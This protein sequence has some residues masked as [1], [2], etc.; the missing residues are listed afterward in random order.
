MKNLLTP[1]IEKRASE[2][3]LTG[4]DAIEAVKTAL[5]DEMNM[6][7]SLIEGSHTFTERGL[8]ARDEIFKRYTA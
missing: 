8:I 2:L 5:I 1:S 6:I 3:M 4:M 7:G